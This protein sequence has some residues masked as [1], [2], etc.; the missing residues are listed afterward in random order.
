LSWIT[1]CGKTAAS[2]WSRTIAA[3][4]LSRAYGADAGDGA[5]CKP[6]TSS[7]LPYFHILKAKD[8]SAVDK[9]LCKGLSEGN[10]KKRKRRPAVE[11][12]VLDDRQLVYSI[13]E[14]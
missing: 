12:A 13:P 14:A 2:S 4:F 8:T 11:V 3:A 7:S 6:N 10:V 5:S 9:G 1:P